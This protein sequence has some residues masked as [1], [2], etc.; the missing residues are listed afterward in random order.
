[1]FVVDPFCLFVL[2]CQAW[3][4]DAFMEAWRKLV[5]DDFAIDLKLLEVWCLQFCLLLCYLSSA[6]CI[7]LIPTGTGRS[8]C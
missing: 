2:F 4:L 8:R 5:P 3:K 6:S 1:M 7:F